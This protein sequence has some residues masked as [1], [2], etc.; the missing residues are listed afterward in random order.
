M[1]QL[2][3]WHELRRQGIGG[4]DAAVALGLSKYKT[5]L[6]LW[7]EKQGLVSPADDN[8]PMFWGRTLEP[9][10]RQVYSD[11]TGRTVRMADGIIKSASYPFM[12]AN[13]DGFTDDNRVVEIK[14]ARSSADWGDE[15]T[16]QIPIP[17]F[18]QV[19]HYMSVT[20]FGVA[21][22]A[23][24][25]GGSD[26]RLYEIPADAEFQ[27]MMIER[28]A[29]FWHHVTSNTPPPPLTYADMLSTYKQ[30]S[31]AIVV[32]S[33][34]AAF[35]IRS[36]KDIKEQLNALEE[37]EKHLKAIIMGAIGNADTLA[38]IDGKILA[39]WKS[40][41]GRKSFD[42]KQFEAAFPDIY[43][44]FVHVGESSRRLLIK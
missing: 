39:T 18:C 40:A 5:P 11:R 32:A 4:S 20:G 35:A 26:F 12:L 13:L 41:A 19:Q 37:A 21:D 17:Y 8:E 15:G 10:I 3:D 16:D 22:V 27:E 2:N 30:S 24:L 31:A 38:D 25:I 6:A 1:Q 14:T 33:Q 28:E 7:E 44:K 43:Q 9:V 36:L 23:V 29:D 34:D 42:A